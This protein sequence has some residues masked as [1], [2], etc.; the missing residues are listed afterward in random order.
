MT[1]THKEKNK[2]DITLT[3]SVFS[4]AIGPRLPR[5]FPTFSNEETPVFA[6]FYRKYR[7][8]KLDS[9]LS[10]LFFWKQKRK[11]FLQCFY[12]LLSL[13]GYN[14]NEKRWMWIQK[15]FHTTQWFLQTHFTLL[16]KIYVKTMF[17]RIFR[18]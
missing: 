7:R 2:G 12:L 1:K 9:S 14:T 17:L 15:H 18:Y 3:I 13:G 16:V 10:I 4:E 6:L 8:S 11:F 5:H